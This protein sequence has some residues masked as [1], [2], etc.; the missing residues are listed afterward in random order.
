MKEKA[1]R[2]ILYSL[3]AIGLVFTIA[4]IIYATY[5]YDNSSIIYFVSKELW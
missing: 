2:I 4:H 3:I 5:L 1:Y